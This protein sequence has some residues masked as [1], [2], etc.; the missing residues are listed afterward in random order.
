MSSVKTENFKRKT[1]MRYIY[2]IE[3]FDMETI[4]LEKAI[5][6]YAKAGWEILS[7]CKTFLSTPTEQNLWT[8]LMRLDIQP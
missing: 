3:N 1:K 4:K 7:I 6:E 2:R 5:N 8:V